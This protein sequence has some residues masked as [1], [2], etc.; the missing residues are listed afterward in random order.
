MEEQVNRI[1]SSWE[2][3]MNLTRDLDDEQVQ[4]HGVVGN[5]STKDT[6]AHISFWEDRFSDVTEG[7][8]EQ[9][10]PE[11]Q[12]IDG[13]NAEVAAD[14]Q[15]WSIEKVW[16]E[17]ERSHDRARQLVGTA[18]NLDERRVEILTWRHYDGHAEDIRAWR[19]RVNI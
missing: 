8:L 18:P 17:L 3:L 7:K 5:W 2:E 9:T 12:T 19:E 10:I 16:Q 1:D 11:G 6:L 15:D 13:L 14:R 4:M